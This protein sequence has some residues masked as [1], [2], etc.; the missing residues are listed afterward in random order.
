MQIN[1]QDVLTNVFLTVGG[2]AVLLAAAAYLIKSVL[3]YKLTLETEQFK[4]ELKGKADVE[5]ERLKNSLQMLAAEHQVR[6]AKLHDKRAAI[7][8]ALYKRLVI[9]RRHGELFVI[10]RE[11]NPDPI[12][13]EEFRKITEELRRLFSFFEQN[14]IYFPLSVCKSLDDLIGIIRGKVM[15]A[16][17]FGRI[18]YPNEHTIQQ[19]ADAFTKAYHTFEKEI[20]DALA[21]LEN[22]FRSMLGVRPATN[23]I[24]KQ[25]GSAA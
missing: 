16:G 3:T 22:E 7:I 12:K 19:S 11:N 21:A 15:I 5:I 13:D 24:A 9:V 14:K 20:P 8:A 18:Q 4:T 23:G 10:T 17:V 25:R 2:S 1:W 6:F